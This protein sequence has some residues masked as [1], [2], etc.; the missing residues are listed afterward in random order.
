[1]SSYRDLLVWD[2]AKMLA[3]LLYKNT[4]DEPFTHDFGLRNQLRRAA[5]SIASNIAEGAERNSNKES[6][7]FFHIAKGSLAEVV[8]QVEIAHEIGYLT[9]EQCK[10]ILT[11]C[12]QI[13]AMLGSLIRVRANTTNPHTSTPKHLNT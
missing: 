1:M 8:T 11:E 9:D 13:N 4:S 12:N 7:Q 2:K 6:V 3:V 10:L 5:V